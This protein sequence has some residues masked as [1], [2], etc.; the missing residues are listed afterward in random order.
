MLVDY[1]HKNVDSTC[2]IMLFKRSKEQ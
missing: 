1:N 2:V